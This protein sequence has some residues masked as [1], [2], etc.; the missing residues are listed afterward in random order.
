MSDHQ[1]PDPAIRRGLY[2]SPNSPYARKARV[3]I[4]EKN[5]VGIEEFAVSPSDN[6]PELWAVNPLGTVPAMVTEEGLHLCDSTVICEY[7]DGLPSAA[8]KL[9]NDDAGA[10]LCIMALA[11]LGDGIMDAA[12]A[13]VM[14]GRRPA[15]K[16]LAAAVLRKQNAVMRAMDKIAGANLDFTLPL[17][18]GT[19]NLVIALQYVDFRLPHLAWRT[20]HPALAAG[21]DAMA[22]R[23]AFKATAPK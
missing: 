21:V 15:D 3:M 1:A 19:L 12:V 18:L 14:E 5:I 7:L 8:P 6:P 23:P 17:T 9:I 13:C 2:Y 4:R 16:Q 11:V 22:E 10:R 20:K